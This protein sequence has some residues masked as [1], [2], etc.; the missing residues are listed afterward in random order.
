MME[1][2]KSPYSGFFGWIRRINDWVEALAGKPYAIPALITLAVCESIFFPIPVDVL[3]IAMCVSAHR[4]S[5]Y[6][7]LLTAVGSVLGGL[8]GYALG[9]WAWYTPSPD[10]VMVYSGLARFFFDAVPGFSVGAFERVQAL[11]ERY[12]FAAVFVAGFTPLPYKV[13]TISAG[14]FEI[15][16]AVFF[17]ASLISRSARFFLVAGLFYFLGAPIK[18]FID[19]YLEWLS[20]AFVVLLIGGFVVIK[21]LI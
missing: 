3:L 1:V 17:V 20:V 19:K 7:A 13:V 6:F 8:V 21:Y 5:L 9:F 4:R 2:A 18:A 11:Y 10:G 15:N 16:L 14:V 12:N